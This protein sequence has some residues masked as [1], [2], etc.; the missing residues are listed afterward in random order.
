MMERDVVDEQLNQAKRSVFGLA[1]GL[2]SRNT[3][4]DW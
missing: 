4:K 2:E 1:K 3:N